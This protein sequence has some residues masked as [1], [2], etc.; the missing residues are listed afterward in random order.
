MTADDDEL[1]VPGLVDEDG[2]RIVADALPLHRHVGIALT[3]PASRSANASFSTVAS[4]LVAVLLNPM[5][6]M[7]NAPIP[8]HA[9][10][11]TNPTL[12]REASSNAIAV[13]SSAPR[14]PSM[15]TSTG[16]SEGLS[17]AESSSWM[18]ATGQW[19]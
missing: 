15:P 10:R 7:A 6:A 3:Q 13:A 9:C 19:A 16:A 17:S 14:D 12:R 4:S 2:A 5:S 18:T 1:G 8:V 11:A